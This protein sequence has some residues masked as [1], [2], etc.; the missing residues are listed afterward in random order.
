MKSMPKTDS[1]MPRLVGK[2]TLPP[3]AARS[4]FRG[5]T[6]LALALLA[7]VLTAC[8]E[9]REPPPSAD[10]PAADA[11]T[12][13]AGEPSSWRI[14]SHTV[15]G[16][17][18]IIDCGS[19]HDPH[20][21]QDPTDDAHPGGAIAQNESLIRWDTGKYVAGALEPAV[22]QS[23]PEHFAF[24]SPPYNG[25][26]QSCHQQTDHFRHDG[27]GP[28]WPHANVGLSGGDDCIPCHSHDNGFGHGGGGAG[29]G[30]TGCGDAA[31]C[32]GT[33]DSHPTHLR[34][35]EPGG[36]VQLECA[37][38]HDADRFPLFADGA[39]LAATS[40][41][42]PCHS[43]D[44]SYD[45]VNDAVIGAKANWDGGVYT[46]ENLSAGRE[47]WCATCHDEIPSVIDGVAAPNVVGDESGGSN[48]GG[49][50]GYYQTGHGVSVTR[51]LPASGGTVAGPG[52]GCLECHSRAI[53]HI[54]GVARTYDRNAAAGSGADYRN[55]YRLALSDGRPPLMMPRTSDCNESPEVNAS[56]FALC[57][58]CHDSGPF[59]DPSNTSTNFRHT[60]SPDFNAHYY[61]LAVGYVCDFG[62]LASSDWASGQWDSR[63]SC[64]TCHNV[65]GSTQLSMVRDGKLVGREPGLGVVYNA[66]EVT[67]HCGGP[68]PY[69]PTP[70]DVSL[71]QSTGTV[72][73]ERGIDAGGFCANCHGSCGFDS[74]YLRTPWDGHPPRIVSVVGRAGDARL[75]LKLSEGVYSQPGGAGSLVPADFIF[76]D[77]DGQRQIQHV[78]HDAGDDWAVIVLDGAVDADGEFGAQSLRA[79]SD[80]AV[81]DAS[82]NAM[83]TT[84]GA[85]QSDTDAPIVSKTIPADQAIEVALDSV[86]R[87]T[88]VD[89]GSGVDPNTFA[90]ELSGSDGY[91]ARFETAGSNEVTVSSAPAPN[92]AP[93]AYVF[94]VT[95]DPGFGATELITASVSVDDLVGNRLDAVAATF[96][97]IDEAQ[98]QTARLHPAGVASN[99]GGYWTVNGDWTDVLDTDDGDATYA[100]SNTGPR[101]A[102]LYVEMDDLGQ[103]DASVQSMIIHVRARYVSGWSPN[104]PAYAGAVDIGLKTG[105]NTIWTGSTLLSA[106]DY[107]LVSTIEYTTDS[108]GGPLD[109]ADIDSLQIAIERLVSG[110]YPLRITEVRAEV[111]YLP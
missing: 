66:P 25:I 77:P 61:H 73:N 81:Y 39:Q 109:P 102:V 63:A 14:S 19:C 108:D 21:P 103:P 62:P 31:S 110:G 88:L 47:R 74:V 44:G 64:V 52:L 32:H 111:S 95:P 85:V 78:R 46:G 8:N 5:A 69:E 34:P 2:G 7:V 38:C 100:T 71:P 60:A 29:D 91:W 23:R 22:F 83:N 75:S 94:E 50:Y 37:T 96:T 59:I 42:D 79:A 9:H 105:A 82:D 99:P 107:Q 6:F 90:I 58:R 1:S 36:M 68:D 53:R 86:V 57:M 97:T 35:D 4:A 40:V 92:T 93:Y 48:Y 24:A 20:G 89:A 45:G 65:H 55:G 3:P 15:D 18:R 13:P 51:S 11:A 72:W 10:P 17:A 27:T 106:P 70:T 43:P 30:A 98:L 56:D 67:F 33:L 54:D 41:C 87:I 104:P 80:D 26:C 12:P 84:A 28:D 16:G 76:L 101:G 49:G